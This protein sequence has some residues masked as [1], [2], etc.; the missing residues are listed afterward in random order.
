MKKNGLLPGGLELGDDFK[1]PFSAC[2]VGKYIVNLPDEHQVP[3]LS[4]I[5]LV[6]MVYIA[7]GWL[8]GATD[9]ARLLVNEKVEARQKGPAFR[10][11]YETTIQYIGRKPVSDRQRR[12][13]MVEVLAGYRDIEE[14]AETRLLR[15]IAKFYGSYDT[16]TLIERTSLP[17]SP[18]KTALSWGD[19]IIDNKLIADYYRRCL[20]ASV[21]VEAA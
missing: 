11:L 6:R 3:D 19:I 18:W 8:L 14:G 15:H 13:K 9:G 2:S 12:Q 1:G 7:H 4:V 10:S 21:K 5:K 20:A 16:N 17:R